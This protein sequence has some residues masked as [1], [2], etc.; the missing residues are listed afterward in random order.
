MVE[1]VGDIC[2]PSELI[3]NASDGTSSHSGFGRKALVL[4]DSASNKLV[5]STGSAWETITSA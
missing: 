2:M 5:F 3:L 1:L 4:Y